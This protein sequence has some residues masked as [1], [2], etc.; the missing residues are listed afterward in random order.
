VS[1]YHSVQSKGFPALSPQLS[2]DRGGGAPD[3]YPLLRV[4]LMFVMDAP[5]LGFVEQISPVSNRAVA[6]DQDEIVVDSAAIKKKAAH[7]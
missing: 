3:T 4:F 2:S 5:T 6:L 1:L 7:S